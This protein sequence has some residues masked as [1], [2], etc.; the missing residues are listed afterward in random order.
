M[1]HAYEYAHSTFSLSF[2]PCFV[3]TTYALV[4]ISAPALLRK[5]H[6]PDFE[7]KIHDFSALLE[8]K[9]TSVV[10]DTFEISGYKWYASDL[11]KELYI[12]SVLYS[13]L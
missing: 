1:K 6:V 5:T 7:W 8:M 13:H 3:I 9:A 12:I 2:L 11:R 10:S 4:Q